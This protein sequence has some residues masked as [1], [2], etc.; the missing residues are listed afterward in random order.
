MHHHVHLVETWC[1]RFNL[2]S[3]LSSPLA[4]FVSSFPPPSSPLVSSFLVRSPLLA[5]LLYFY[6]L[7]SSLFFSS[8]FFSSLFFSSLFL[9]CNLF[10]F[11]LCRSLNL[12]LY[13][14]LYLYLLALSF[15]SNHLSSHIFS[16]FL[17][18]LSISLLF[19]HFLF[20]PSFSHLF[21]S[22]C[23]SVSLYLYIY[24]YIFLYSFAH[25]LIIE[26]LCAPSLYL[27]PSLSSKA[28]HKRYIRVNFTCI[29]VYLCVYVTVTCI[30]GPRHN[31][32]GRMST[33]P[34]CHVLLCIYIHKL[35]ELESSN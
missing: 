31:P 1:F 15:L 9:S 14:F 4:F 27:V 3:F 32:L 11:L 20:L 7:F 35:K 10:S 28:S 23:L 19:S 34:L 33:H 16:R 5:S 24:R 13:I 6:L 21:L 18:L 2:L 30:E 12:Y 26:L 17:T 22:V 25:F 8:L 29:K